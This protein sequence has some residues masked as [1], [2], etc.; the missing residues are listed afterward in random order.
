MKFGCAVSRAS[1][2][3]ARNEAEGMPEWRSRTSTPRAHRAANAAT[4]EMKWPSSSTWQS[5]T[6]AV[7]I[8]TADCAVSV[9]SWITRW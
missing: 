6:F 9:V 7:A 3:L 8:H 5:F 1:F 4:I 2:R